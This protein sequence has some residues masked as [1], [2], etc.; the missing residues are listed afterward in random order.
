MLVLPLQQQNQL[1]FQAK[2]LHSESLKQVADYAVEK[3]KFSQL[4]HARKNIDKSFFTTRLRFDFG[5]I[6]SK[7][8]VTFTRY[9]LKPGVIVPQSL[10]DYKA[11]KYYTFQSNKK[12][13]PLKF[14]LEQIL[15]MGRSAPKNNMYK[16]V[17]IGK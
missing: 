12:C 1:N 17:V 14:A 8:Y 11:P 10:E 15:K 9:D 3:G 2:F 4:N 6:D 16:Q 13:N 7:P 5:E